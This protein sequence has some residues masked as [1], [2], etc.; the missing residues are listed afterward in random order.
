MIKRKPWERIEVVVILFIKKRS[1]FKTEVAIGLKTNGTVEGYVV[2]M[3]GHIE[4]TDLGY[5]TAGHR[6]G[7]EEGNLRA[8]SSY[9]VAELRVTVKEKR[10]KIIVHVTKCTQWT[11]RLR[12]KGPEFK[13]LR[14][15]PLSQIPWKEVPEGEEKWMKRVL[16]KNKRCLVTIR[17]GKN[18]KDVQ[19]VRTRPW[20]G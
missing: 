20:H 12:K 1:G 19:N 5:V 6:E 13:W 15:V 11:G 2:P 3:G 17:C 7:F 8:L 10:R 14:F 16:L 18:R 4:K 9:K